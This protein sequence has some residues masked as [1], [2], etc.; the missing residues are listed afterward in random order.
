MTCVCV[1]VCVCDIYIYGYML[2]QWTSCPLVMN[3]GH[4]LAL[5]IFIGGHMR[6]NPI[7]H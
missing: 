3:R 1:C 7:T 2:R 6:K 5:F 4:C